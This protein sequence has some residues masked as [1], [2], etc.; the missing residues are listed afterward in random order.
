MSEAKIELSDLASAKKCKSSEMAG[1]IYEL[2]ITG[3]ISSCK[4][5]ILLGGK[6]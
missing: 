5:V 6:K 4:N 2:E 1:K 3:N